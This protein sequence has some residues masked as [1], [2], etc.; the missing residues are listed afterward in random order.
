[1]A[2]QAVSSSE[3]AGSDPSPSMTVTTSW[4]SATRRSSSPQ[5]APARSGSTTAMAPWSRPSQSPSCTGPAGVLAASR[6]ARV[7]SP[8]ATR[9]AASTMAEALVATSAAGSYASSDAR[10]SATLLVGTTCADRDARRAACS[11]TGT[12]FLLF[13]STITPSDAVAS[14][15]SRI[16]AVEGFMDWPPATISWT[17]RDRR[18]PSMPSPAPTATT[19]VAT[20]AR[21]RCSSATCWC[22]S[23]TRICRGR[24]PASIPASTAAPM[25]S[26]WT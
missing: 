15:A 20:C 22:R 9:L 1:M 11:A 10:P 25:S 23:V 24:P 17:P 13:G 12:T 3:T 7:T 5:A 21:L 18:I 8:Q 26:V 19:A 2:S 4:R 14:M 16:W 6:T